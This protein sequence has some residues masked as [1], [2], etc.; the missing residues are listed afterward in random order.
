[1][2]RAR[3]HQ[4]G[5][6]LEF[7]AGW[8]VLVASLAGTAFGASPVPF[9]V[10]PLVMGPIHDELGWDFATISV[11]LTIFSV[12]ASLLAPVIGSLSDRHGVRPVALISLFA[13][14]AVFAA[15]YFVPSNIYAWWAAWA[16]LGLIAIGSTPVTWSRAVSMWFV[17]N[18]GLALGIM[19]L[20]TSLAAFVVPQVVTRAIEAFGWRSAFPVAA[21]LPLL[22]ALPLSLLWFR[23]PRPE[24]LVGGEEEKAQVFTGVT[25]KE[26]VRGRRFWL[27]IGSILL[28]ALAY[29]G[30]HIHMAQVV[31]LHGYTP[32]DAASVLGIIALGILGGRVIVGLLFDKLWAPGVACASLLLPSFA[33]FLLMGTETPLSMLMAG[34][35]LLGFAAGAESDIVAFLAARY[36]GMKHYGRIYGMLY[37]PFGIGSGASPIFYGAVRDATGNYDLMFLAAIFMFATAGLLLLGLGKYPIF[38][39]TDGN[40]R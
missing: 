31:A 3:F 17:R 34:G 40:P 29:G 7:S 33:C 21:L 16:V 27:L 9:N 25:L 14:A 2:T 15:F 4:S 6:Y 10:L 5:S 22:V 26:A 32:I 30:A 39:E 11:G 12:I 23:T 36:F 19:L 20:G 1:M 8:K 37:L 28:A 24:E 18:R 13:F 38:G 35:F